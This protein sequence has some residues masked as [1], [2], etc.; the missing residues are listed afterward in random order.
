MN[1]NRLVTYDTAVAE[2]PELPEVWRR[3]VYQSAAQV[4]LTE[5]D[6]LWWFL[7]AQAK[8][9]HSFLAELPATK[10]PATNGV[11][12]STQLEAITVSLKALPGR[13]DVASKKDLAA[14]QEEIRKAK[15]DTDLKP[16][17]N[18]ILHTLQNETRRRDGDGP[19]MKWAKRA[20]I[21]LAAAVLT[22][23]FGHW[24]ADQQSN[25]R[26]LDALKQ[27]SSLSLTN[28]LRSG[29]G[30]L[31]PTRVDRADGKTVDGILVRGGTFKLDYP[32]LYSDNS[33]RI[34]LKP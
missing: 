14:L 9:L 29:G 4:G 26:L 18:D 22:Y 19:L 32:V 24:Q 1:D 13:D 21:A 10:V 8:Q 27:S 23:F 34:P 2:L 15:P 28:V 16:V 11:L 20:G 5:T 30:N 25:A 12:K 6:P 17:L 7:V 3:S 31:E 33:V